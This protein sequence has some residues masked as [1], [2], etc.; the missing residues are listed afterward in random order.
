MQNNNL[1]GITVFFPDC[2][3]GT[4]ESMRILAN[5][6]GLDARYIYAFDFLSTELSVAHFILRARQHQ[7]SPQALPGLFR[8][9]REYTPR[10]SRR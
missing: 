2:E 6:L 1:S 7:N 4:V 8:R 10:E 5:N 9:I 3:L